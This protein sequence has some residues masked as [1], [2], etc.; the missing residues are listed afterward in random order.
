M[1][2]ATT[3]EGPILDQK[4]PIIKNAEEQFEKLALKESPKPEDVQ[5]YHNRLSES[6]IPG[7]S[8]AP[9][10]RSLSLVQTNVGG[11]ESFTEEHTKTDALARGANAYEEASNEQLGG[12]HFVLKKKVPS[13]DDQSYNPP[14][15]QPQSAQTKVNYLSEADYLVNSSSKPLKYYSTSNN[16][17]QA[18]NPVLEVSPKP[19]DKGK[20]KEIIDLPSNPGFEDLSEQKPSY[21]QDAELVD[22]VP[23][24]S[25]ISPTFPND[26][27]EIAAGV[28]PSNMR[29]IPQE[30]ADYEPTPSHPPSGT[31]PVP[32]VLDVIPPHIANDLTGTIDPEVTDTHLPTQE[33][34]I[35]S[36]IT[37][38]PKTEYQMKSIDW[39]PLGATAPKQLSIITQN[40]N[41]PC[42]LLA[43]CNVLLL[44]GDIQIKPADRPVVDDEYLTSLLGEYLL[45]LHSSESEDLSKFNDALAV[46]PLLQR[47]LD[48]NVRFDSIRGFE[49]TPELSMFEAFK[50]DLIHGWI[51]DPEEDWNTY[52]VLTEKCINYNTAVDLVVKGDE[53]EKDPKLNAEEKDAIIHESLVVRQFLEHTAT[54]LTY[55]GLLAISTTLPQNHLVVLFRNNHFSTLYKRADGELYTLVTDAG[56]LDSPNAVWESLRDI[57]QIDSEFVTGSFQ[58]I[59]AAGDSIAQSDIP[60]SESNYENLAEQERMDQDLALALNLQQEEEARKREQASNAKNQHKNTSR[61]GKNETPEMLNTHEQ[62]S[63]V[64]SSM[65]Q[66]KKKDNC[67]IC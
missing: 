65:S 7:E 46:I 15:E 52:K 28:D 37:A 64:G 67:M 21:P 58:K 40:E 25:Q 10:E 35:Q 54:Q 43:L 23:I 1:N 45:D 27:T 4:D 44:R 20:G 13:L 12:D 31:L 41:G 38:V 8:H 39:M 6:E 55:H 53:A 48:V 29:Y 33:Q 2:N 56:F 62:S 57:D 3:Q 61:P 19:L 34:V 18:D 51:A 59:S 24:E 60:V 16:E 47:G 26:R 5:E 17:N 42:P 32:N 30:R 63:S 9:I 14:E 49:S 11:V 66:K 50:V 36:V 22:A